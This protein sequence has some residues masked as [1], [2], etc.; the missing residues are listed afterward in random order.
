MKIFVL[1]K[2]LISRLKA[3]RE[4]FQKSF[5][6]LLKAYEK[7]AFEY[8]KQY[9]EHLKKITARKNLRVPDEKNQ[10]GE[11][12]PPPEPK[13]RTKD[14]DFYIEMLNTHGGE[15]IW[16]TET[17]FRRLWLDKW[18]WTFNHYNTLMYYAR[19]GGS[20]SA[21]IANIAANYAGD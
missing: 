15:T 7:K 13:D 14:Y 5:K 9:D 6:P 11:P 17:L 12:A 10:P 3:N 16:I 18:D 19:A 1:K 21:D 4:R 20:G 8:Q 2:D